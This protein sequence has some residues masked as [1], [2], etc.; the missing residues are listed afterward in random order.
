MLE[1]IM[2]M[3]ITVPEESVG[4][5]MGD[6]NARRGRPLG[7]DPRG[8]VTEI[9]ADVPM[10]EVLDYAPDLRSM[11]GGQGDYS[12]AFERHEQVPASI[13]QKVIAASEA[14]EESPAVA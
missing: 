7:M 4:D 8:G 10:A 13:A 3:T 14:A 6:L 9:S 12:M 5:V 2:R 11:T 1:P